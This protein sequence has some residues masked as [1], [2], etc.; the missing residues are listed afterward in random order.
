M[1]KDELRARVQKWED[2][3]RFIPAPQEEAYRYYKALECAVSTMKAVLANGVDTPI[4][5]N[6]S[7]ER[8]HNV[9]Q[10]LDNLENAELIR[11]LLDERGAIIKAANGGR[12]YNWLALAERFF[13][14]IRKAGGPN[15]S[16]EDLTVIFKPHCEVAV[17]LGTYSIGHWPRLTYLTAG[18]DWRLGGVLAQAEA[19]AF[20][21]AERKIFEAEQVVAEDHKDG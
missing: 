20:S 19:K 15:K 2:V 12:V 18:S 8:L 7:T 13:A 21:Q 16:N 10:T 6:L 4:P 1:T 11:D 3:C 14:A 17:E 9:R 5:I